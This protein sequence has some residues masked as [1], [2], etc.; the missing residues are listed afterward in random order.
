MLPEQLALHDDKT[1]SN[2]MLYRTP[3]LGKLNGIS[4]LTSSMAL[5][6]VS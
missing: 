1:N 4:G 6:M 3:Y 5:L 2:T